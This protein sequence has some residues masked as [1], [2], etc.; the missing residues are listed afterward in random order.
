[1]RRNISLLALVAMSATM[2]ALKEFDR[3]EEAA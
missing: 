1:M 2:V 3:A